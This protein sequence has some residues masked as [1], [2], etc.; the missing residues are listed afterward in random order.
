MSYKKYI[1]LHSSYQKV[2]VQWL[3]ELNIQRCGG[4]LGDEMGLGKTVQ[5]IAFLSGLSV[6]KLLSRH[7]SFKG[8]GPVLI[9]TPTTVMHQWIK[10][11]HD[12]WP[13]LR[14]AL[15]HESGNYN[16]E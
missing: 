8:L 2:G 4:I 7:G 6:S 11:F 10:E 14:A 16:G 13:Q 1:F 3:W 5:I 12:W 15:M 9:V